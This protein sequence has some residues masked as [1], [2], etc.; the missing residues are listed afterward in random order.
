MR[1]GDFDAITWY[2]VPGLDPFPAPGVDSLVVGYWY[3][4]DNRIVLLEYVPDPPTVIRHEMLH[5]LLHR[6]DHPT[7]YFEERCGPTISG[8]P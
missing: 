8:P 2:K 1:E 4:G 3:P 5:A 6:I 7:L